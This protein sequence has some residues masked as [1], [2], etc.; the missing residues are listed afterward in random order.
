LPTIVRSR[1]SAIAVEEG[2][3]ERRAELEARVDAQEHG[4][5]RTFESIV[6][7]MLEDLQAHADPTVPVRQLRR[8]PP[9]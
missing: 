8:E 5:V 7:P 3:K 4:F 6:L 9:R 1:W 2:D